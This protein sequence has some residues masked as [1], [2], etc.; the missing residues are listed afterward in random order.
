MLWL[1]RKRKLYLHLT[2]LLQPQHPR[3][4]S[5][6]R[7]I[8][9]P[10]RAGKVTNIMTC[11]HWVGPHLILNRYNALYPEALP[12]ESVTFQCMT[13]K[14]LSLTEVLQCDGH[15]P[16]YLPTYSLLTFVSCRPIGKYVDGVRPVYLQRG[17]QIQA[18]LGFRHVN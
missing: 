16:T 14:A 8:G 7:Q 11:I 12:S 10:W 13:Y 9:T 4:V 5:E 3:L 18:N 15:L 6:T 1:I 2:G 17:C